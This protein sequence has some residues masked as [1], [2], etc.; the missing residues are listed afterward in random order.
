MDIFVIWALISAITSWCYNFGFKVITQRW[1]STYFSSLLSYSV[2]TFLSFCFLIVDNFSGFQNISLFWILVFAFWNIFF[3]YLSVISRIE[4]MRNID[5]VIFYPLY[6]TFWPIGVTLISLFYFQEILNLKET[7]G[8]ILWIII[9]LLLITKSEV[10]RQKNLFLWLVL[11]FITSLISTIPPIFVKLSNNAGYDTMTYI[12]L[13]FLMWVVFSYFGYVYEKKKL[14]KPMNQKGVYKFGIIIWFFHF[15]TF[16]AFVKAFEGN[17]AIAFTINS[18][19]ILIPI[20][21]SI[22]FYGEHFNF[23]KA[24]VVFLSIISIFLFI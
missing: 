11:M 22:F 24:F 5:N 3:F 16:Y 14:K 20:V 9:P 1:Y 15:I 10:K 18:F 21:L 8:I 13:S 17:I 19:A 2:A 6:K 7:I 12:F 4:S 23:K